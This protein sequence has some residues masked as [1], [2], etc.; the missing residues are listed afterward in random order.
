MDDA[1]DW[2]AAAIGDIGHCAGYGTG[3]RYAAEER[4]CDI[5]YT[6]SYQLGVAVGAGTCDTVGY[7]GREQRLDG[8]EHGDRKR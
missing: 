4:H 3:D 6:L 8:S 2:R 7:C 1:G 5:G